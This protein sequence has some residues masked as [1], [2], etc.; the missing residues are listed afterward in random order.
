[1]SQLL[2][3][4]AMVTIDDARAV[5]STLPRSYEAVVRDR[6]KF[7]VG[8]IVFVAFSRDE[9]IMGFAFPKDER[10]ALVDAEPGKFLMPEPSD[11]RYNWVTVRL[12]AIDRDELRELVVEAW[13]MCVPKS[14]GAAYGCLPRILGWRGRV[15]C[16]TVEEPLAP[17]RSLMLE[18]TTVEPS[19][20][21]ARPARRRL[22]LN[23]RHAILT[24]HYDVVALTIATSLSVFKP[25]RAF[26]GNTRGRK[27]RRPSS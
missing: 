11:L 5:A 18:T 16:R 19:V 23:A 1:M 6:V 15:T 20:A 14:V 4:G 25:G 9:S 10:E 7:R 3:A 12:D 22:P 8:R 17:S 2:P 24:A 26:R 21:P 13:R 27:E